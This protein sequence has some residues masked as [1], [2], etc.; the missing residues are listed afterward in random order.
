MELRSFV[1]DVSFV[2]NKSRDKQLLDR[3]DNTIVIK[4]HISYLHDQV[5]LILLACS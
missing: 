3:P 2:L 4:G 1:V 5:Q